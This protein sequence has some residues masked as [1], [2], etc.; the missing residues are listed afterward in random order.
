MDTTF[1]DPSKVENFEDAIKEN[2]KL[3]FIE[4]L[5][6]SNS[7]IINI[8]KVAD[9]AHKHNIPLVIDSTFATPYL[10]RPI[11]HGAD[12]VIHSATK[13]IGGHGTTLGGIIVENGTFYYASSGKFKNL[14]E[15]NDSY[16]GV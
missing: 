14:S 6:N 5:G 10:I 2:T 3:I 9:I 8:K 16:H 12:V 13:F 7:N 4:T 11:E 15:P 1:V